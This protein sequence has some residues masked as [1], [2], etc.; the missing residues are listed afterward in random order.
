M[1]IICDLCIHERYFVIQMLLWL[2][3]Y[4]IWL[5]LPWQFGVNLPHILK[6]CWD[7]EFII[8]KYFQFR[9][10]HWIIDVYEW[11]LG[12]IYIKFDWIIL[13]FKMRL[14][15]QMWLD[16]LKVR[17]PNQI[18]SF[19]LKVCVS[20]SNRDNL[21]ERLPNQIWL[22]NLKERLPNQIRLDNLRIICILSKWGFHSMP[23]IGLFL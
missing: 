19:N 4:V 13:N 7:N 14:P 10:W 9:I 21:G 3:I 16:N 23:N 12:A 1:W 20:K 18:W 11:I 17:F 6:E 5:Q 22:D 8:W 15:N 2:L